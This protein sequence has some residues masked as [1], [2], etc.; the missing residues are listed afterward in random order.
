MTSFDKN[1]KCNEVQYIIK[2][3]SCVLCELTNSDRKKIVR[4][5]KS[6]AQKKLLA[7]K[8][9]KSYA[10]LEPVK[11]KRLLEKCASNYGH[12]DIKKKQSL[13]ERTKQKYKSMDPNKKQD[14]VKKNRE[15]YSSLSKKKLHCLDDYISRFLTKISE[16]PYYICSVCNRL[17]YRKS[18]ISQ[19]KVFKVNF[20]QSDIPGA[21]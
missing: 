10:N 15:K 7:D 18:V 9:K 11:K 1:L 16:G 19:N 8:R 13:S 4:K 12:M 21:S 20:C 17:L 14:L 5:H 3:L 6:S 2:F